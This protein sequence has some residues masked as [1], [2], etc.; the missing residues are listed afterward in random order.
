MEKVPELEI[1]G[2]RS[3][4]DILYDALER[5]HPGWANMARSIGWERILIS[6]AALDRNRKVE[7]R[8]IVQLAREWGLERPSDAVARLLAE[9]NGRTGVIVMSTAWEDVRTVAAL[10]YTALISD[11]LYGGGGSPHPRLYGA[12][13]C[14]L[15]K[16]VWEDALLLMEQAIHKMTAMPAQ[17]MGFADRGRIAPG[18]AADI[19]VFA[20]E[21][22]RDT[23]TYEH[24]CSL[25]QGM[26]HLLVNGVPVLQ[27][28]MMV[29]N[30]AGYFVRRNGK[31]MKNGHL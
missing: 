2:T 29:E 9:E 17:R 12:F 25:A 18:C 5:E 1:F 24:P 30:D 19:A 10:P 13:P 15:R 28:G 4:Q 3:G 7:G 14:F 20:P 8:N 23:A 6:S 22:F 21:E 11:A 16:L 31:E 27:N 26:R